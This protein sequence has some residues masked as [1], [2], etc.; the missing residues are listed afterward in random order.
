M[1]TTQGTTGRSRL[2]LAGKPVLTYVKREEIEPPVPADP[3]NA[4][5]RHAIQLRAEVLPGLLIHLNRNHFRH[6]ALA[7][8]VGEHRDAH[9][10]V[11]VSA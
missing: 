6:A 3:A 2:V 4:G 10:G 8:E 1:G 11:P 7:R 5:A 9:H